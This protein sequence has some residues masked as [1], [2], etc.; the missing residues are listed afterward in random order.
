MMKLIRKRKISGSRVTN[1]R[2]ISCHPLSVINSK[3]VY[4]LR[5]T[6]PNRDVTVSSWE[7]K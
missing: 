7:A 4:M 5:G 2:P 6:V 1:G 3:R